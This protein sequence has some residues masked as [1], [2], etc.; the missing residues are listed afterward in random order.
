MGRPE[1]RPTSFRP[2][3]GGRR[4]KAAGNS[5]VGA[6]A[7]RDVTTGKRRHILEQRR[8]RA[9]GLVRVVVAVDEGFPLAAVVVGGRPG[10]GRGGG[11][12][13]GRGGGERRRLV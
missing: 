6:Q 7:Y 9:R 3:R 2:P 5:E 11:R 8:G 10:G 4:G 13:A 12:G 1:G